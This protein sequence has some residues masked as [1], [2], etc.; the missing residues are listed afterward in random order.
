MPFRAK[1]PCSF[2]GCPNITHDKYCIAHS[3]IALKEIAT[4]RKKQDDRRGTSTDRG[5]GSRWS[6]YRK[7]FLSQHPL[8]VK[9]N[10]EGALVPATVVDHI[11]PHRGD[12]ALMWDE[13]NHQAMCAECHNRKT[14]SE[15]GGYGRERKAI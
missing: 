9:C 2:S 10:Q 14:A 8:C 12:Y 15:D 7:A 13:N 4:Q 6:R 11:T 1:H 3:Y 5:Y